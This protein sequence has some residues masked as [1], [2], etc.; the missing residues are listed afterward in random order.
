MMLDRNITEQNNN[1]LLPMV[2]ML[3]IIIFVP[4]RILELFLIVSHES[5]LSEWNELRTLSY[6]CSTEKDDGSSVCWIQPNHLLIY[7]SNCLSLSV[8]KQWFM[9][10]NMFPDILAMQSIFTFNM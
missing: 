6:N 8:V 2:K 4:I 7:F 1:S 5:E 3:V 10:S 9:S